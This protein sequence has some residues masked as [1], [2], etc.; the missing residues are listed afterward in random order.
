LNVA[1]FFTTFNIQ[2]GDKLW[3]EEADRI[4]IW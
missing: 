2:P 1:E 4:V 3:R